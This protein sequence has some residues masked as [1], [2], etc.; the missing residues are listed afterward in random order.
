MTESSILRVCPLCNAPVVQIGRRI[1][2]SSIIQA[3]RDRLGI[4]VSS[5][6]GAGSAFVELWCQR[7]G[8]G[9][10]DPML[11]GSAG[12]Y[13]NLQQVDG[14]YSAERW[15]FDMACE[16]A[17]GAHALL[18]VGCGTGEFLLRQKRPG[19]NAAG[20]ELNPDAVRVARSRGVDARVASVESLA[21]DEPNRYDC[22]CSFQV[23]EHV[24]EPVPFVQA[25]IRLL[26]AGGCLI[27]CVPNNGGF[28]HRDPLN[29][30]NLPPHHV[31]LWNLRSLRWL[32]SEHG[33]AV[34]RVLY[35]PLSGFHEEWYHSLVIRPLVSRFA[36][37]A[38]G[39][40]C[41]VAR[42]ALRKRRIRSRIRGER[43]YVLMR[44]GRGDGCL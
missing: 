43:I 35:E 12:F 38:T 8:L 4:D 39:T 24:P 31:L 28:I 7:C 26:R 23:L 3:W 14:Y 21:D 17:A 1:A 11:A 36:G 9:H 29:I 30:W 44:K 18:E 37:P 6:L 5:E 16:D 10:F 40:I 13:A 19:M 41:A 15:E 2:K 25:C 22:V 20:L 33:L 42:Q 32:A 34:E 27:V